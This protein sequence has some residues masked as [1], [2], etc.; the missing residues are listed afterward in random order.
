MSPPAIIDRVERADQDTFCWCRAVYVAVREGDKVDVQQRQ[1]VEYVTLEIDP[2]QKLYGST[3]RHV[4]GDATK[5]LDY[6]D[7][8]SIDILILNGVLGW[9]GEKKYQTAQEVTENDLTLHMMVSADKI[10]KQDGILLL[11]RNSRH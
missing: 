5:L 10:L 7:E 6:F 4:V 3:D 1:L 8:E 9:G 11:G 2:K